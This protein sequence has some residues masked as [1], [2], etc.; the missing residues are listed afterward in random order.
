MASQAL[1]IET[2]LFRPLVLDGSSY[3]T[4][5][6]HVEGHLMAKDVLHRVSDNFN[7]AENSNAR[8][9]GTK[10]FIFILHHLDQALRI[11]TSP[12]RIHQI[13]GS[14]SKPVSIINKRFSAQTL[15]MNGINFV[16][17]ISR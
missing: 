14:N 4:G 9:K 12:S 2:C 13:S 15:C 1:Q 8:K 11:N 10:A 16:F 5:M 3:M 17:K 6:V 7:N